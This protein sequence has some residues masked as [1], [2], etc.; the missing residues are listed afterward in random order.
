MDEDYLTSKPPKECCLSIN[1]VRLFRSHERALSDRPPW[2]LELGTLNALPLEILQQIMYELDM[3]SLLTFVGTNRSCGHIVT[4]LQDFKLVVSCP[5]L[6]GAVYQLRCR[7]FGLRQL[8]ASIRSPECNCCG[9]FGDLFYLIT[10]ERLCYHCWRSDRYWKAIFPNGGGGRRRA[11]STGLQRDAIA[12]GLPHVSVPPGSYGAMGEGVMKERQI[13]FDRTSF[14]ARLDTQRQQ[15]GKAGGDGGDGCCILEY[16]SAEPDV[17]SYVATV[18]APYFDETSQIWEEGFFCRACASRG[19]EHAGDG[20]E[21][22]SAA[23]NYPPSSYPAWDLPYRRYTRDGMG[24][25]IHEH[26]RIYKLAS[27]EGGCVQYAHENPFDP[28]FSWDDEANELVRMSELLRACRDKKVE[29]EPLQVFLPAWYSVLTMPP[30]LR[31]H[32]YPLFESV[33][34]L[35]LDMPNDT[36]FS[37]NPSAVRARGHISKL[38]PPDMADDSGFAPIH[39]AAVLGNDVRLKS[40][41]EESAD[42]NL[43]PQWRL[44]AALNTARGSPLPARSLGNTI[45]S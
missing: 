19:Q 20:S 21:Y 16:R 42:I 24:K 32:S 12:A 8:A 44:R 33:K 36:I 4:T 28:W 40:L 6:A 26:G 15:C 37:S 30:L 35:D 27:Q 14:F 23:N 29:L 34:N 11:L 31:H 18:R 45:E 1:P 41:V 38:V 3:C 2:P 17:S 43:P 25:H 13:A 7:S 22:S 10:A 5:Q 39:A 9:R